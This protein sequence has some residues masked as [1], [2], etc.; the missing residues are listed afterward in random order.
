MRFL[1]RRLPIQRRPHRLEQGVALNFRLDARALE[2]VAVAT[3]V[4][5][6][7]ARVLVEM[8]EGAGF[9]IEDAAPSFGH[10]FQGAQLNEQRLQK[11]QR[12]GAGVPR[13]Q[14]GP[15]LV[16]GSPTNRRMNFSS[17]MPSMSS[18]P[19]VSP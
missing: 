19:S 1:R 7:P 5:V 15:L 17:A 6:K 4:R 10:S 3:E 12:F 2:R 8:Q 14:T 9:A 16:L 11:V 13:R 18:S